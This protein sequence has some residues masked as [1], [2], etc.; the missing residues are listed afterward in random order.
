MPTLFRVHTRTRAPCPYANVFPWNGWL[1]ANPR[2]FRQN[3]VVGAGFPRPFQCKPK[4]KPISI[5]AKPDNVARRAA[6]LKVR[7]T[8]TA[9]WEPALPCVGIREFIDFPF[10][11]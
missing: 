4:P 2:V 5:S 10:F 7:P 3:H 11:F 6:N 9:G 1:G 8:K